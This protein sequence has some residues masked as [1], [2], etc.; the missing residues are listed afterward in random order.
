MA[1]TKAQR[2]EAKKKVEELM[3]NK[4]GSYVSAYKGK[5]DSIMKE[6]ENRVPFSY[7]MNAD[8]LYK[9]YLDR[10]KAAGETAM[11]DAEAS[12]AARTGGYSNSYAA[13]AG[14]QAYNDSLEKAY[15][16]APDY[17]QRALK[18]YEKEG[19]ELDKK[20][21]QYQD[22]EKLAYSRYNDSLNRYYDE[23]DYWNKIAKSSGS[24][25]KK[26][27]TVPDINDFLK[28]NLIRI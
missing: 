27:K 6:I 25:S 24:G 3:D 21:S 22:A 18:R 4:P 2:T 13:T 10:S 19:E 20:L 14:Q 12:A 15:M 26:K 17:E 1:Y 9:Q 7:N 23:L 8:A 5:I 16:A 28:N 11:M